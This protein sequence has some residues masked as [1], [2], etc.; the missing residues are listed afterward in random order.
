MAGKT[1]SKAATTAAVSDPNNPN[2]E[3]FNFARQVPDVAKKDIK[4]GKLK[5]Y[6]NINP[7]WRLEKLT[8]KFGPVGFGWVIENIKYWTS[9]G[10][11]ECVMWCS[12]DLKVCYNG[13]WSLPINGIGGSKLYGKGQGDGIND[14]ACKMA[15][16]DAISVACKNL[17]FASDIYYGLD[18][19]KYRAGQEDFAWGRGMPV[20]PQ[21]GAQPQPQY[22]QAPAPGPAPAP[23]PQQPMP[24]PAPAPQQPAQP[25]VQQPVPQPPVQAPGQPPQITLEQAVELAKNATTSE[26]LIRL[27][28]DYKKLYGTNTEFKNAVSHNPNNPSRR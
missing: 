23:I 4:A 26:E 14:E 13:Q 3:I 28:N 15:Q 7:Q 27:W 12:L 16:T 6:T 20:P 24:S 2:L 11:G 1:T 9:E 21:P 8:E 5:G 19:T 18:D 10:L 25:P 17:G 22:Q